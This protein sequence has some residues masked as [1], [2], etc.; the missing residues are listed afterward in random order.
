MS[1]IMMIIR[2]SDP[3]S[4]II[5]DWLRIWL[6]ASRSAVV[7]YE[8]ARLLSLSMLSYRLIPWLL[9]NTPVVWQSSFSSI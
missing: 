5:E 9:R 8:L 2:L 3:S 7:V 6:I 4:V 1:A